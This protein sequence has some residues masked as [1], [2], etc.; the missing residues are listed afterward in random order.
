MT[1]ASVF[2]LTRKY[3][4]QSGE[5][6]GYADTLSL[7]RLM[8]GEWQLA[9]D[10]IV[11]I[12]RQHG[13]P[14]RWKATLEPNG[15]VRIDPLYSDGLPENAVEY[16][17]RRLSA[18]AGHIDRIERERAARRK[19][20]QQQQEAERLAR[21]QKFGK[22]VKRAVVCLSTDPPRRFEQVSDAARWLGVKHPSLIGAIKHGRKCGGM[23]FAYEDEWNKQTRVA[24]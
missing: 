4:I 17:S 12:V 6:I 11:E 19:A 14:K 15:D 10:R 5:D 23:R 22:G 16:E 13:R 2:D 24:G 21:S 9:R 1:G 20:R 18:L 8:A 7:A 3:R